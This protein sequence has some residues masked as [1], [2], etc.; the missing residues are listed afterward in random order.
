MQNDW[1]ITNQMNFLYRAILKK[2]EFVRSEKRD[3]EHCEFCFGKFGESKDLLHIGY[4][5]LDDYHWICSECFE[6][7]HK[8]FEWKIQE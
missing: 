4:C 7:F 3:H 8:M 2:T 5:T 6:D 1:R